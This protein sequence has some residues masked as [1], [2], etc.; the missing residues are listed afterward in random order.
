MCTSVSV[1]EGSQSVLVLMACPVRLLKLLFK[2]PKGGG[3]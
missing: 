3:S 2:Q 1:D